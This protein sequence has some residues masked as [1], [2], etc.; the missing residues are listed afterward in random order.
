VPPPRPA[1]ADDTP[2]VHAPLKPSKRKRLFGL[3]RIEDR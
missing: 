2:T 3:L 1:P